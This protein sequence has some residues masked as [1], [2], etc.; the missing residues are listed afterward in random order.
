MSVRWAHGAIGSLSVTPDPN[1]LILIPV[2]RALHSR[3]HLQRVRRVALL[4]ERHAPRVRDERVLEHVGVAAKAGGCSEYAVP[5][6]VVATQPIAANPVATQ[7]SMLR[8]QHSRTRSEHRT[9][10]RCNAA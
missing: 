3:R 8:S 9:V 1:R 10:A 2:A 4:R 5:S 7:R 6:Y